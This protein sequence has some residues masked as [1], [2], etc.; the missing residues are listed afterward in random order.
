MEFI[1]LVMQIEFYGDEI[2]VP[3]KAFASREA[4][5]KWM[6][7]NYELTDPKV[8]PVEFQGETK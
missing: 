8:E 7:N 3:V 5:E 4:A 6:A 1:F 2:R